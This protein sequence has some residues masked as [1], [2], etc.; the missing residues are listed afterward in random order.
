MILLEKVASQQ[1]CETN[2]IVKHL[3]NHKA[4]VESALKQTKQRQEVKEAF[5]KASADLKE[6][7][8]AL[9]KAVAERRAQLMEELGKVRHQRIKQLNAHISGLEN[10][11]LL[12][13]KGGDEVEKMI[14]NEAIVEVV[15]SKPLLK[16]ALSQAQRQLSPDVNADFAFRAKIDSLP[17]IIRSKGEIIVGHHHSQDREEKEKKS[18][19]KMRVKQIQREEPSFEVLRQQNKSGQIIVGQHHDEN[20]KENEPNQKMRAKQI[21]REEPSFEV[22]GQ[23]NKSGQTDDMFVFAASVA[24][25]NEGNII[26]TDNGNH[27]VQVFSGTGQFIRKFGSKGNG[28]G[29]FNGPCGVTV[30]EEGNIIVT[31]WCNNRVQI[32]SGT[33]QF[34]RKFGSQGN[35][36][37]Q[38]NGPWGVTV[39]GE[40]NIIVADCR[41]KRLSVWKSNGEFVRNYPLPLKPYF[42]AVSDGGNVVVSHRAND[43]VKRYIYEKEDELDQEGE[44]GLFRLFGK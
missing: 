9:M 40:G 4:K 43:C 25:D 5:R 23:Q 22:L 29:Q 32:F 20:E 41:N 12:I 37:G 8:D 44:F 27:R 18:N 2:D 10:L 34:I 36:D 16:Q 19:Q 17:D 42:I 26:V 30:D 33:G 11:S 13:E 3:R 15:R 28:D 6:Y 39:D 24:F 38:F 35:G 21:Q 1:L 31:D 7:F 14:K